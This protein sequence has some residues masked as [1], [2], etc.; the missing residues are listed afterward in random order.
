MKFNIITIF[1]GI[2]NGFL[3][4]SLLSKAQKKKLIT[5]KTHYLRDWT[6][7]KHQT[8]DGKPYGGGPGLVFKIEPIFKAVTALKSKVKSNKSKVILF[9][10]RGKKFTNE[11]AKKWSRI[12]Q[13]IFICGRY[14]G[15]DERVAKY[16]ADEV[17][18]I[19]DYVLNGGEVATMAVIEAVSRQLPGFMHDADSATKD[20][21]AQYTKPEIFSPKKGVS[22]KVPKILLS[23]DHKKIENWRMSHSGVVPILQSK[24]ED[25][26]F[27]KSLKTIRKSGRKKN[28]H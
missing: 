17:I 1:P 19:G 6:E 18:S 27:S 5:I 8:V 7:D 20:D 4:E 22:W 14:E 3:S 2:F 13:L 10:P 28:D 15:V 21:H 24:I 11:L 12:D 25:P 23:G 16:I 26:R 9:S